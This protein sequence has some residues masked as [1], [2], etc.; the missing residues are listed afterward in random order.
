MGAGSECEPGGALAG[1]VTG[2]AHV[3]GAG[4]GAGSLR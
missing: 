2:R 3:G 1:G 4:D